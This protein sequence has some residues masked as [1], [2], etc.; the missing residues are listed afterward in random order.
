MG[1]EFIRRKSSASSNKKSHTK[2]SLFRSQRFS[3][4]THENNKVNKKELSKGIIPPDYLLSNFGANVSQPTIQRNVESSEDNKEELNVSRS[5]DGSASP[6]ADEGEKEDVKLKPDPLIP[7]PNLSTVQRNVESSEENKEEVNVNRSSNGS[8]SPVA[9]EGEK[10]EKISPSL[11]DGEK[12]EK[13]SPSLEDGKKEEDLDNKSVQTKLTVGEPGDKYE[14]EADTVAAKVVE[15]IN[16][17]KTEQPVQGKVEPVVKPTVMRQGGAGGGT[18]NQDVEQN[19]QQSR[20]GG[21]GLADNVRQPMEQAFGTDFSGVKVHTDGQADTL[22]RSLNSRAFA[23][24]QDIFFKQGEYNPGSKQGQELLAHELTHVV[25]QKNAG[26]QVQKDDSS[27]SVD[28]PINIENAI[29]YNNKYWK[30][31]DRVDLLTYLRSI[32]V[33]KEDKFTNKDIEEIIKFQKKAGISGKGLDGK[34]GNQTMA[35]LLIEYKIKHSGQSLLKTQ[36]QFKETD[37][38]LEFYP[39]E[40]ED[41]RKWEEKYK[42]ANGDYQKLK[43]PKGVGQL[44]IKIKGKIVDTYDARGGPPYDS[45]NHGSEHSADPSKPGRYKLGRQKSHVTRS[46]DR[47]MIPWGSMVTV[48][49]SRKVTYVKPGQKKSKLVPDKLANYILKHPSEYMYSFN[50]PFKWVDNDFGPHS[51]RI[52]GSPGLFIHTTPQSE[53]KKNDPDYKLAISHGCIHIK[54]TDRD[55]MMKKGYLSDQG[56]AT[57]VI[58]GGNERRIGGEVRKLF[59]TKEGF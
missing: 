5:S 37:I 3:V 45:F 30:G 27:N 21:Q 16:S 43:S 59:Q 28:I 6:V 51:W 47:S 7:Y 46:W 12:E 31:Q 25:Q 2:P 41:E 34:I 55:E 33:D 17:P 22:N 39:C 35:N 23:T 49:S 36:R 13:L 54:P 11:E 20:G 48:D 1:S 57:I 44:Y 29:K 52:K 38:E 56:G 4:P 14:Q 32:S 40:F 53:K 26:S 10:E 42:N 8:V 18:V 9:D 19:I 50:V 58:K 15:Q 24:G